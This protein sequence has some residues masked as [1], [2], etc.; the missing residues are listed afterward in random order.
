VHLVAR[1]KELRRGQLLAVQPGAI[2]RPHVFDHRRVVIEEDSAMLPA[3]VLLGQD[4]LVLHLL[5]H[6]T[7][8]HL[9]P[10]AGEGPLGALI[11]SNYD[12]NHGEVSPKY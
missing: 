7:D 4:D 11:I 3:D 2:D 6:A 8:E 5:S 9:V 10:F 12:T 1:P